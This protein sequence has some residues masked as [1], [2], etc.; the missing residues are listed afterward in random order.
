MTGCVDLFVL[1]RIALLGK[2][3]PQVATKEVIAADCER[4]TDVERRI[5]EL[6]HGGLLIKRVWRRHVEDIEYFAVTHSGRAALA[7]EPTHMRDK[8]GFTNR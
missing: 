5:R 3:R 7:R 6:V 8:P 2:P 4:V 1:R